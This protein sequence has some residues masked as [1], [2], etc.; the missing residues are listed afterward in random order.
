MAVVSHLTCEKVA[1]SH[2]AIDFSEHDIDRSQYCRDIG[3]HMASAQEIHGLDVGDE[4][5]RQ[6]LMHAAGT[7]T[8]AD[9]R[10][11]KASAKR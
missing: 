2:L 3:Q 1:Q 8:E 9:A 5:R 4:L 7:P 10:K 6:I 11:Q